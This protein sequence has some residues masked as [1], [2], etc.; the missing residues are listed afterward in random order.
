MRGMVGLTAPSSAAAGFTTHCAH[1]ISQRARKP[2]RSPRSPLAGRSGTSGTQ[3]KGGSS[4]SS[5]Q[6]LSS[7][8][9]PAGGG[10]GVEVVEKLEARIGVEPTNK[11]FADLPPRPRSPVFLSPAPTAGQNQANRL[12]PALCAFCREVT[13]DRCRWAV[14]RFVTV[15]AEDIRHGDIIKPAHSG[16]ARLPAEVLNIEAASHIDWM[17]FTLRLVG[18]RNDGHQVRETAAFRALV[19]VQRRVSCDQPAC[20]VH[21]RELAPGIILCRDHWNSWREAA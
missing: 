19:K 21:Q 10:G 18:G 15:R 6:N 4:M 7:R 5:G 3:N 9:G 12:P 11:G 20:E 2:G 14:Q 8:V 1:T 17:I 13:T 16:R